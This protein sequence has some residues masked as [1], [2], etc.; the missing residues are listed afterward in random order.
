MMRRSSLLIA[1]SILLPSAGQAEVFQFGSLDWPP[2]TDA[3]LP[4]GGVF[5]A[6]VRAALAVEGHS[7][8]VSYQPWLRTVRDARDNPAVAG[9][10]PIYPEDLGIEQGF[11]PSPVL[12]RSPL[13]LAERT[14]FPLKEW[15]SVEGLTA[16]RIGVVLG[17]SNGIAFDTALAAGKLWTDVAPNDLAN[18][19]KLASGRI[20]AAVVDEIVLDHF[21]RKYR[22]DLRDIRFH[23]Q[24]FEIKDLQVAFRMT[25]VG[26]RA[27]AALLAG[28]MKIDPGQIS[29]GWFASR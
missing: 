18:L 15:Q 25:P 12:M 13:G 19:R 14:G 20:D 8:N 28:L 6:I 27:Q 29:L 24:R 3:T 17:Y 23:P 9:A 16:Y 10:F 7:I 22:D 2:Y 1:F 21:Q 4:E 5:T 11:S 26:R